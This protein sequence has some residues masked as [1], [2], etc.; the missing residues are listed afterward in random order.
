MTVGREI[1]N[2]TLQQQIVALWAE[3]NLE[4]NPLEEQDSGWNAALLEILREPPGS[5]LFNHAIRMIRSDV[6]QIESIKDLKPYYDSESFRFPFIIGAYGVAL[7]RSGDQSQARNYLLRAF[8][9]HR[10]MKNYPEAASTLHEYAVACARLTRYHNARRAFLVALILKRRYGSLTNSSAETL[11]GFVHAGIRIRST[12][13]L[14]ECLSELL[15]EAESGN[16]MWSGP[17][18]FEIRSVQMVAA[19]GY[20]L[21][22]NTEE[23]DRLADRVRSSIPEPPPEGFNPTSL[24]HLAR[25]ELERKRANQALHYARQALDL[26]EKT[27]PKI[28]GPQNR[29]ELQRYEV[30]AAE[31]LIAAAYELGTSEAELA[32]R[33]TEFVR[34]RSLLERFGRTRVPSPARFPQDL[35]KRDEEVR[36]ATDDLLSKL[37]AATQKNREE[38]TAKLADIELMEQRFIKAIPQEFENYAKLRSGVPLEP[39][40][41]TKKYLSSNDTEVLAAFPSG[42]ATF[43]WRLD[44]DGNTKDWYRVPVAQERI[45]RLGN[46]LEAEVSRREWSARL[47]DEVVS[48]LLD[49]CLRSINPGTTLCLVVGGS[50]LQIPLSAARV[51]DGGYLC[52]RHPIVVLPSFS[53]AAFWDSPERALRPATVFADSLGDL[54]YARKE[55]DIV[56]KMFNCKQLRG[57]DVTR[58]SLLSAMSSSDLLHV[59]CHA[60]YDS[61]DPLNSGIRLRGGQRLTCR[62]LMTVSTRARFAFLSACE[63]GRLSVRSGDELEG[64][65][66]SVMYSG[67]EAAVGSLWRVPD[68]ETRRLVEVFYQHLQNGEDLAR[69][70]QAAQ[71]HVLRNSETSSPYFWGAWQVIGNWKARLN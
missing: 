5:N 9:M 38:L 61:N 31:A 52:E 29:T 62:D 64:L 60:D 21:L 58:E 11:L 32:L 69:S 70:L 63:T 20:L 26:C 49:D 24:L 16:S 46:S 10:G 37:Q 13:G 17:E 54:L 19:E 6:R 35:R 30:P 28:V 4:A 57:K 44:R 15:K 42:D 67:F 39:S 22:G 51:R 47:L 53:V 65:T 33:S 36:A 25:F 2:T 7:D 66:S 3:I 1:Q 50:L 8:R 43:I 40:E 34:V 71:L 45:N 56:T 12:A 59:A 48:T 27:R 68:R 23:A 55:A 18:A 14:A 41:I